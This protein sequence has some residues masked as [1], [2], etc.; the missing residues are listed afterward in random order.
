MRL[1]EFIRTDM[2]ALLVEWE[3]FA[4]TLFETPPS[5]LVLRDH[6]REI[7]QAV[8]RDIETA[9]SNHEQSEKSKGKASKR[10]GAPQTA[11]E[12]H[13]VLRARAGL[14]INQLVAEYRALRASVL[15]Q[16]AKVHT[17]G[18]ADIQDVIRFNEG[19]DQA[20]AES[21][22]FFSA[23]VEQAR[24]LL[25]GILGHDMRSPL[26]SI[27]LTATYLSALNVSAEVSQAA[28]RLIRSGASMKVLLDDL[29][30]FSRTKLGLGFDISLADADLAELC[31][32]ELDQLRGAH[33]N[34][35]I[36]FEVVG[37]TRGHWDGARLKQVLRNLVSNA[38]K[39]G[40]R[41]AT[42]H[43]AIVD[44]S[45][46]VRIEVSN[47]G[48]TLDSEVLNQMFGPLQRGPSAS[49]G[50]DGE[51]GLGLGLYIAREVAVAHGGDV[52]ARSEK[53]TTVFA[54]RLPRR[55]KQKTAT[56]A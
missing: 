25:L 23:E 34:R 22:F 55:S 56:Q 19:I 3:A 51:I 1:T 48:P 8:A 6:A 53:G 31:H 2:E 26:S 35:R 43:V 4:L 20:I 5:H 44:D 11:A 40:A 52:T 9:Q 30:D 14:E 10:L 42:V 28:A 32:D 27:Q 46:T 45:D 17:L 7:L 37:D 47:Q 49:N 16:W 15:S 39:H 29:V 50:E 21:I 54:V 36:E 33:P 24:N 18:A 12:T 41:D 13:A 38:M